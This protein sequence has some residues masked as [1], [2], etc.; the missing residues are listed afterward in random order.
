MET[1]DYMQQIK[2]LL[3]LFCC[4]GYHLLLSFHYVLRSIQEH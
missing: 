1:D 2:Q 4:H 3:T